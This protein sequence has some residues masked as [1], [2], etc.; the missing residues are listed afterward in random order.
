M[1]LGYSKV[2][3]NLRGFKLEIQFK[4]KQGVSPFLPKKLYPITTTNQWVF[5]D[6]MKKINTGHS[7][8]Y[9]YFVITVAGM[10]FK[11]M[12]SFSVS[13]FVIRMT[14]TI[15]ISVATLGFDGHRRFL[16]RIHT[17]PCEAI[18]KQIG[19]V[20]LKMLMVEHA[21]ALQSVKGVAGI[22]VRGLA[23]V[24]LFISEKK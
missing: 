1:G 2:Y 7:A 18:R 4:T 16:L 22:F 17:E 12:Y 10:H 23:I 5:F 13:G 6:F 24:V 20:A 21:L 14:S 8:L 3:K 9:N 11:V 19:Q 15:M